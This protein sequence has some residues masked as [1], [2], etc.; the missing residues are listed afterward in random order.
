MMAW[1]VNPSQESA[2]AR[3]M[4][5]DKRIET[6]RSIVAK[7][8]NHGAKARRIADELATSFAG[9]KSVAG[10]QALKMAQTARKLASALE[11]AA[12]AVSP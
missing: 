3:A 2:V 1:T 6:L 5:V 8:N 4:N 12:S 11:K 10:K 7:T 9:D